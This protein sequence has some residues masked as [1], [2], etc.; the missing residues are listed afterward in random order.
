MESVLKS[1]SLEKDD[2][3]K[4]IEATFQEHSQTLHRRATLLKNKVI[5][6]Y[7]DHAGKLDSDMDEISTAL[8]CIINLKEYQEELISKGQFNTVEQ[9]LNDLDEVHNNIAQ[10]INPRDTHI[11]FDKKHGMEKFKA[12][13]KDLGRVTSRLPS[14]TPVAH[15]SAGER[16]SETA[17]SR[18]FEHDESP[19][20]EEP[21][22]SA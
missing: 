11:V 17:Q 18:A 2:A 22:A 4:Q 14:V 8:A 13:C 16:S 1:M 5:D 19:V 6:I 15:G 20:A 7:K 12:V 21:G 10:Q 9:G 3:L